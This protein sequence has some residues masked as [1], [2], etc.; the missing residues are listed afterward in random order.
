MGIMDNV[1]QLEIVIS[2]DTVVLAIPVFLKLA[3]INEKGSTYNI[4]IQL[5]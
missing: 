3:S 5:L 4:I 2:S 1:Y